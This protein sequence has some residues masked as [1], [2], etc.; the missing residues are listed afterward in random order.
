[1]TTT[2]GSRFDRT[3]R[4]FLEEAGAAVP[5][6]GGGSAA[7]L[8]GALGAAMVSMTANFTQGEK[9]A[10]VGPAMREAVDR[11]SGWTRDCEDLLEA[12]IASFDRY[13]TALKLPKGTDEEKRARAEALRHASQQAIEV[14][15]ALMRVCRDAMELTARLAAAGNPNVISD[16]GIGALLFE[17]SARS[18]YLT[19]E[20][21][22]ASLKDEGERDAYEER[23]SAL[24]RE[25]EE[26]RDEAVGRVR[27]VIWKGHR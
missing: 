6:P 21:N 13:M 18:A 1:M 9:F 25:C 20:I 7:A 8:V 19:V 16:L 14:P 27:A 24:L 17:T 26:W 10:D 11:L 2:E 3:I 4:S 12:D 22:L 5:T 23:A 15:L